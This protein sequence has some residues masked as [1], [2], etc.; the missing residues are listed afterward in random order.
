[1][2]FLTIAVA[3]MM[4]TSCNEAFWAGM[5]QGAQQYAMG[6]TPYGYN[7]YMGYTPVY[8]PTVV[9]NTSTANTSKPINKDLKTESNGFQWYKVTQGNSVG[10][11][12][13]NHKTLIPL[14]R[15]YESLYFIPKSGYKG[16]FNMYKGNKEG[17]CDIT[18]KEILSP[19]YSGIF[20]STSDGFN[21]K[22]T[23]GSYVAAGWELDSEG[24]AIKAQ[25]KSTL[26]EDFKYFSYILAENGGV[27]NFV[28]KCDGVRFDFASSKGKIIVSVLK[29]GT[30]SESMTISPSESRLHT[31]SGI[32]KIFFSAGGQSKAVSII[33]TM[34]STNVK[35]VLILHDNASTNSGKIFG[36]MG[37][38][39]KLSVLI[40]FVSQYMGTD[41]DGQFSRIKT[42]LERYS[43][44]RRD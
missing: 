41:F 6:M 33:K 27:S 32:I 20:Y 38:D 15:G 31:E 10:A 5:A 19:S 26:V 40:D 29:D 23:S 22:N 8:T 18:G 9:T 17:V 30:P 37:A 12:D 21:Y 1:M 4:L 7:P 28:N 3:S 39:S 35:N 42:E 43:W 25:I 2:A 16:Y 36:E 11:E 44:N 14:S 13:Y 24:R 34:S